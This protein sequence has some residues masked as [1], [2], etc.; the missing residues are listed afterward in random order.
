VLRL[1]S[2]PS[3]TARK[4]A[5]SRRIVL[6]APAYFKGAGVPATPTE[7]SRHAAVIY[8]QDQDG[9][10]TWSFRQ[11]KTEISV[12]LSGRLR[13]SASE[14]LRAAVLGGMGLA[15]A[16]QWAFAADLAR[17]A[18]CAVLSDWTLPDSDLWAVFPA[19]RMSKARAFAAFVEGA[20]RNH[21]HAP[22]M[23]EVGEAP[24]SIAELARP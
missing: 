3:L 12:S 6:G 1:P 14:G 8:T 9:S 2:R 20:L 13:V 17:G 23:T 7:L 4:I 16:S 18:V 15:I 21:F 22:S 24:R 5:S 10:D 11:G 19:R